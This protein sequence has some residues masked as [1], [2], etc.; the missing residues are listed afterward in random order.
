MLR[1]HGKK[2]GAV[3]PSSL[4]GKHCIVYYGVLS[5][6][7]ST[8]VPEVEVLEKELEEIHC[9]RVAVMDGVCDL[10]SDIPAAQINSMFGVTSDHIQRKLAIR[11]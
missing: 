5:P 11:Y 9:R 2:G 7:Q 4:W 8:V 3:P 1:E 10:L 6:T